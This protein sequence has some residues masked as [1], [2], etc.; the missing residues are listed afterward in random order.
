[1]SKYEK[2]RKFYWLKWKEDFFDEDAI[3]SIDKKM[4]KNIH[5]AI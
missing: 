1:M 5:Y 4:E 2:D 3:S